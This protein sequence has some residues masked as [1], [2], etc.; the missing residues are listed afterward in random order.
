MITTIIFVVVALSAIVVFIQ[1]ARRGLP[2]LTVADA[3]AQTYDVDIEAF[4]NLLDS[5]Q[6]EYVRQRLSRREFAWY[7]RERARVLIEYV[8]RI[9]HNS[10]VLIGLAHHLRSETN[11]EL[12]RQNEELLALAIRTRTYAIFALLLLYV[13]V[14]VP[15]LK[16]SLEQLAGGYQAALQGF[17]TI[18]LTFQK[19]HAPTLSAAQG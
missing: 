1:A 4:G 17:N 14:R 3:T 10:A 12:L 15:W 16:A 11:E 8:T 19:V 9:S 18:E 13:N 6:S 2:V 5:T 7:R